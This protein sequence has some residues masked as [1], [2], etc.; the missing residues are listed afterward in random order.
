MKVELITV[1]DFVLSSHEINVNA[2]EIFIEIFMPLSQNLKDLRGEQSQ[3][4]LAVD[5]GVT[6]TTIRNYEGGYRAPSAI[7]IK[8]VCLLFSVSADWLLFDSKKPALAVYSIPE[9]VMTLGERLKLLRGRKSQEKFA[10]LLGISQSALGTY[11]SD[12]RSPDTRV[13]EAICQRCQVTAD[14]LIFGMQ[15]GSQPRPE[16]ATVAGFLESESYNQLKSQ[17]QASEPACNVAGYDPT[18]YPGLLQEYHEL[19]RAFRELSGKN[20][21]LLEENGNLR[22]ELERL[23]GQLKDKA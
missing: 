14:W 19:N 10:A 22:L 23:R 6:Q 3:A 9:E 1:F 17:G 16:H 12:S 5:L 2:F 13:I 4:A 11:E 15:D 7:F 18:T 21:A 8:R 20:Q